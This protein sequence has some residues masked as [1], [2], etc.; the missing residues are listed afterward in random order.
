MGDDEWTVVAKG[1]RRKMSS[2]AFRALQV[3]AEHESGPAEDPPDASVDKTWS[4]IERA[5]RE[6]R[7]APFAKTLL[8]R[9]ED[10]GFVPNHS[11]AK[12]AREG[13]PTQTAH[14]H[15]THT[16]GT[17]NRPSGHR[18]GAKQPATGFLRY[19]RMVILGLGSPTRS[20]VSRFQL[21]LALV[22]AQHLR[23]DAEDVDLYDP[24]FTPVDVATLR[25]KRVGT[26]LDRAA[27]DAACGPDAAPAR[28]STFW[29]MP[30]CEAALYENV[31]RANGGGDDGVSG[32]VSG[33]GADETSFV[34]DAAAQTKTKTKTKTK[35]NA[36]DAPFA[37]FA[38][39]F[40][41]YELRWVGRRGARECPRRVLEAAAAIA[42]GGLEIEVDPD[43]TFAA[44]A[45][46][47]AFNDTSVQAWGFS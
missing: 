10:A 6:I 47:G 46:L 29:Y 9:M 27:A 14:A 24:V 17:R 33:D 28:A 18:D 26:V 22:L 19:S 1:S 8:R 43:G 30:H 39:R 41:T 3:R 31:L 4:Q 45:A 42:R 16:R 23:I 5:V 20:A 13:L 25:A 15:A 21:A 37:F 44:A 12:P 38:N 32:G 11:R 2:T 34:V 40:E 7:D 36:N 35:T